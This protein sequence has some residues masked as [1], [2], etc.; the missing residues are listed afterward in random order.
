MRQHWGLRAHQQLS[1]GL[2]DRLAFTVTATGTYEQAAAVAAKWGSPVTDAT[3]HALVQRL[4]AQAETQMQQRLA[5]VPREVVPPRAPSALTV[6]MLDG[7]QVRQ[8]GPGWGCRKTKQARVEWHE[9]KT[10][11]SS[12]VRVALTLF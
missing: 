8:R 6:L 10:G 7:W 2:Q 3:L 11:S 12:A 1:P 5:T 9:L 4:G